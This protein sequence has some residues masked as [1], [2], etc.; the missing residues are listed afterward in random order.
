[1]QR[2]T[3]LHTNDI[4][5]RVDGL[6]RIATLIEETRATHENPV[7]YVDAGDAEDTTNRLSNLTK[8]AALQRLLSAAGCVAAAVGNSALPRYGTP[9]LEE[10]AR[11]AHHP[12]LVA[13]IRLPDGTPP[14]GGQPST[15]MPVGGLMLGMVGVTA[16]I[17]SYTRF[18]GLKMT[19]IVQ[20][21]RDCAAALRQ[22][23][24]DVVILLSHLGLSADRTLAADLQDMVSVIIGAH[25]HD[26]LPEGEWVGDVL[27]VQAGNY[28]EHL[29]QIDCVWDD[30][31]LRI[32]AVAVR[33]VTEDIPPSPAFLKEMALIEQETET[34]FNE[35]IA[36]LE[37]ALDF[38][39]DR[40]CAIAAL[41]AQILRDRM[42]AEIGLVVCGQAFS[43]GLPGGDLHR[44]DLWN[45]ADSTANP[46]V[47]EISG[48]NLQIMA[49][50]GRD[51]HM[52]LDTAPGLRGRA[53]GLMHFAGAT[54]QDNRLY[55]KGAPLDPAKTYRVAASDFELEPTFGY[56]DEEWQL[57]P[58]YEVPTIL[59]EAIEDHF[60]QQRT[61]TP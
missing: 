38:A 59:R 2:F 23:G 60:I 50:R 40:E 55:F 25:S 41:L 29:G 43:A 44:L 30:G 5:G 20:T 17:S 36:V 18:F 19:P 3:V 1:M 8:G 28:A 32:T 42:H 57:S 12:L 27:I 7:L 48:E 54:W 34:R 35:V 47:V 9:V 45:I 39:A 13:N 31:E 49:A 4:H 58:S 22:D 33:P 53:R 56:V 52:A 61:G 15:L 51:L 6:A 46:G 26:L 11:A 14:A 10:H 37:T 21:V 16:E 24:A